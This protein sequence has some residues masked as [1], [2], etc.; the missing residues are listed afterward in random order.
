MLENL[1]QKV[2]DA[3]K[4]IRVNKKLTEANIELALKDV[5]QALLSADVHFKVVK[6]FI[7][8]VQSKCVGQRIIES[9]SAR[10]QVIKIINDALIDLLQSE[11]NSLENKRPLKIMMIGLHGSGK[12]TSAVKLARL[13]KTKESYKPALIACDVYRP[14]AI[15]Q[16][17]TLGL[18]DNCIVYSD[19]NEKNVAKIAQDGLIETRNEGANCFIFDTAGRLQIDEN[20]ISEIQ[21][22]KNSII[23]DEIL[24]VADAALGQEAVNVAQR[25]HEAVTCTGIILTKLD[26]DARGGAALSMKSITGLPIKFM[27]I[28]EKTDAFE[29]FHPDRIASRILGMGD[30]V[31]LVEKAQESIDQKEAEKLAKKIEKSDFN[32]EDFF[33]QM[34]Q[35]KKMG[36]LGSIASMMPG[37]SNVSIGHKEEKKMAQTEAIISSMT[38]YEKKTPRLLKGSRLSRVAKGSG[39]QVK[40]VNALLKQFSQM[41]KMMRMIQG[42]K[43][44]KIINSIKGKVGDSLDK[45][46]L[47]TS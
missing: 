41:Q 19:R 25:F 10:D 33:Q 2:T 35:I 14:A 27:G 40:D 9:I 43:G 11:S 45:E 5:R 15:E 47:F 24:L 38:P 1:T 42:S 28:G 20:L 29:Y 3:L 8:V 46:N 22:L 30:V 7:R 37:M 12:T 4:S 34:Q 31:S 21:K 39:T 36:T 16:L 6:E 23:P 17:E 26:G 18:R 32:L 44:K 13:L